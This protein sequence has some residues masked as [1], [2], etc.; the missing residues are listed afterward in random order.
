MWKA[1]TVSLLEYESSLH[2]INCNIEILREAITN[3]SMFIV[4]QS[5]TAGIK[6]MLDNLEKDVVQRL[7]LGKPV[8]TETLNIPVIMND[9]TLRQ[10]I[11][12][13]KKNIEQVTVSS[14][15]NYFC[16]FDSLLYH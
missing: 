7:V 1:H 6:Y 3:H 11:A 10:V 13:I 12:L 9:V 5:G 2:A 4:N 14:A 8:I 16:Y 15:I